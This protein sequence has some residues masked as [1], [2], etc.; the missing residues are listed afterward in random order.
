ML[1]SDIVTAR[2]C[3]VQDEHAGDS[4]HTSHITNHKSHTLSSNLEGKGGGIGQAAAER[5][6]TGYGHE[7]R[8]RSD[9]AG[10]GGGGM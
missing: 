10:G 5:D 8:E 2:L 7:R 9:E 1:P 4:C 3:A 6:H